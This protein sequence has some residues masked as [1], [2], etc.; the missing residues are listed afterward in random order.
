MSLDINELVRLVKKASVDAVQAGSPMAVCCGG[1][2]S[3]DPLKIRL[4][5]KTVLGQAQLILTS[6]V[7]DFTVEMTVDHVTES[8]SHSHPVEDTYTGGGTALAA[9]HSHPYTGRKAFRVHL[10]LRPGEK[11]ILLRCD[12]GQKYI[13]LDRWEAKE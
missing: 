7:R 12:G 6:S 10:S 2:V 8:V 3:A 11:V 9:E 4:D 5:Q 1:V 13:V